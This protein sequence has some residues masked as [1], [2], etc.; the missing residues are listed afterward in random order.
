MSLEWWKNNHCKRYPPKIL[1]PSYSDPDPGSEEI[2][3]YF[4]PQQKKV[5]CAK[6]KGLSSGN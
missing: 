6:L 3:K 5:R 1:Q 2:T 4:A